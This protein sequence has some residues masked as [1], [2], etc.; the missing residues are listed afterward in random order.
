FDDPIRV[1]NRQPSHHDRLKH[2]EHGARRADTECEDEDRGRGERRRAAQGPK[3]EAEVGEHEEGSGVRGQGSDVLALRLR[4]SPASIRPNSA[5]AL[6]ALRTSG[7]GMKPNR[8]AAI[9]S[10]SSSISEPLAIDKCRK[11]SRV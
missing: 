5:V 8:P 1:L 2:R 7:S 3:R 6:S 9:N 11:N 4:V 10:V